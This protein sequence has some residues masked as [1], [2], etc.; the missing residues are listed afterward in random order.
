MKKLFML[1]VLM[2]LLALPA[3]AFADDGAYSLCY[4][5]A[6]MFGK[7]MNYDGDK[8]A[9]ILYGSIYVENDDYS[10][11]LINSKKFE[12]V[13]PMFEDVKNT[14]VNNNQKTV[15]CEGT[16]ESWE[17]QNDE[18]FTANKAELQDYKIETPEC[19]NTFE[20]SLS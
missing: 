8:D 3:N 10:W 14:M 1:C 16:L 11:A 12:Y 15:V 17:G 19:V 7:I 13:I 6:R 5:N 2:L 18:V 4:K 20:T 9:A